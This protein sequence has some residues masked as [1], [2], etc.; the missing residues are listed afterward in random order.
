MI[1]G[2]VGPFTRTK[3][4]ST[5]PY[6]CFAAASNSSSA[7]DILDRTFTSTDPAAKSPKNSRLFIILPHTKRP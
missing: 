3:F 1:S 2:V 5:G 6:T 7:F 4:N